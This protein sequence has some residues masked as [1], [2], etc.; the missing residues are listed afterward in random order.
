MNKCM[1]FKTDNAHTCIHLH[2]DFYNMGFM[3]DIL[4][5]IKYLTMGKI[6][7]KDD[8]V[9]GALKCNYKCFCSRLQGVITGVKV[10][11]AT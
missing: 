4:K 5:K 2:L 1:L 11:F 3:N 6:I 8:T 10:L 7:S 9:I